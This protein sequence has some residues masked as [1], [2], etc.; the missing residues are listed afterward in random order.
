MRCCPQGLPQHS[1]GTPFAPAAAWP[2]TD[3]PAGPH[4]H[5][6]LARL[7]RWVCSAAGGSRLCR[8]STA[9]LQQRQATQADCNVSARV[10]GKSHSSWSLP[11]RLRCTYYP[12]C[13]LDVDAYRTFQRDQKTK[14]VGSQ[15]ASA[16]NSHMPGL[17]ACRQLEAPNKKTVTCCPATARAQMAVW[18]K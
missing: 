7:Q 6:H 13:R 12:H 4:T 3:R 5:P 15:S 10:A 2:C 11:C 9:G 14:T 1:G 16:W 17:A 18:A 8:R